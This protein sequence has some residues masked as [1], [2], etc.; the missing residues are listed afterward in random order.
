MDKARFT[1]KFT[2]CSKGVALTLLIVHHMIPNNPGIALSFHDLTFSQYLATSAK[3]CVALF[4]ILSGYGMSFKLRRKEGW[5]AHWSVAFG[6]VKKLW[7][8]FVPI[9][10][11]CLFFSASLGVGY[12]SIYGTGFISILYFLKDFLG[13]A[14][15]IVITPTLS[16]PWWYL[17]AA[18]CCYLLAPIFYWMIS[19][20]PIS[21]FSSLLITYLPWFYYAYCGNPTMHTDRELFYFFSFVLGMVLS[22]YQLLDR[23]VAKIKI[24]PKLAISLI[25]T[26]LISL[27]RV[28]LN[29][30]VDPFLAVGVVLCSVCICQLSGLFRGATGILGRDSGSIY[31]FHATLSTAF[32][33]VAFIRQDIRIVI[34]ILLCLALGRAYGNCHE[35]VAS[36][37]S[38]NRAI[39]DSGRPASDPK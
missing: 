39:L 6:Q 19:K 23:F 1:P 16:G 26:F 36:L 35:G 22:E 24:W 5:A 27:V 14:N 13:F 11:L 10:V 3:C 32:S 28:K 25:G 4:M 8:S 31:M 38:N 21:A 33:Q 15:L 29:L 9:F 30:L 20:S 17:E 37:F 12:R 7:L 2:R 18:I 34:F